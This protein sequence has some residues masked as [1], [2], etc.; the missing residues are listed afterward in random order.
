[1]RSDDALR[2]QKA[3][4]F[5]WA[6][7]VSESEA[8]LASATSELDELVADYQA[9]V[10]ALRIETRW[11]VLRALTVGVSGFVEEL[12]HARPKAAVLELLDIPLTARRRTLPALKHELESPGREVAFVDEAATKLGL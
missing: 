8:S 9:S 11:G 1:M 2:R 6:I 12:L 7:S 4:L 10:E 3:R 5:R